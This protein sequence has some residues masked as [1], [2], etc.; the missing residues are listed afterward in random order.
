MIVV[1]VLDRR[2]A[3]RRRVWLRAFPATLGRDYR[4]DLVLDDRYV[5]PTHARL[6]RDDHGGMVLTDLGS[7]NGILEPSGGGRVGR[8]TLHSGTVVRLGRTVLRFIDPG[9][10]VAP[11]LREDH[12]PRLA[13]GR[14]TPRDLAL[15]VASVGVLLFNQYTTA[16]GRETLTNLVGGTLGILVAVAAWAGGWA[17]VGRI[18]Q[19]RFRF[20]EHFLIPAAALVVLLA[21]DTLGDYLK[22]L[23]PGRVDWELGVSLV[24]LT[25]LVAALAAH[26]SRVSVMTRLRKWLWSAAIVG[27]LGAMV[28]LSDDDG[29]AEFS[30][31]ARETPLKPVGAR[32]IP[33][34]SPATFFKRVE[35]L[36]AA[37]DSLAVRMASRDSLHLE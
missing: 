7:A 2:G 1:E 4:S 16:T 23:W 30:D 18:T 37:V 36:Q 21:S 17:L 5:D 24:G 20:R 27:V 13:I 26:L 15:A 32:W 6:E 22:F 11:A 28:A 10:P 9:Q 34:E 25:V 29:D 31:Q 14:S 3:V 12:G 19:H 33:T 8:V 35:R